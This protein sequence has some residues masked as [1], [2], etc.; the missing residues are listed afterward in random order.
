MV[1][2]TQ[3]T[4]E[5]LAALRDA[6]AVELGNRWAA[7]SAQERAEAE[8]VEHAQRMDRIAASWWAA[9]GGAGTQDEPVP[10]TS[11]QGP[12][13]VYPLGAVVAHGGKVWR[14]DHPANSW[15]PG[16]TGAMWVDITP[17]E[18]GEIP[19]WGVGQDVK[20]GDLRTHDG[21]VWRCKLAH[22]THEGWPPSVHTH[23]VWEPAPE[24]EA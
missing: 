6:V 24:E 22:V 14:N 20:V 4:T 21:Q 19:A 10:W 8:E 11:P 1:D 7:E 18:P 3:L 5:E 9:H 17:T 13:R 12:H 16:T 15:E 23:A 2:V